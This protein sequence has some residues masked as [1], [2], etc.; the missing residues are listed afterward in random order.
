MKYFSKAN[1]YKN[2]TGTCI[3]YPERKEATSYDWWTFVKEIN[4]LLVFNNYF[5]SRVTSKHQSNMRH[6]LSK[7]GVNID[8]TIQAPKG[9]GN[10]EDAIMHYQ[11][12][13]VEL[14]AKINNPRSRKAKNN[15]RMETIQEYKDTIK[16]I[17]NNL[18]KG[19]AA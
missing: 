6:L 7:L 12:M 19:G 10:L 13:S 17:K 14:E 8:I 15:E 4:G 1:I 11:A 2:S 9:L 16:F 3:Y 5:Y 18:M